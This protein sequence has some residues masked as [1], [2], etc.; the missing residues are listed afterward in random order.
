MLSKIIILALIPIVTSWSGILINYEGNTQI[1]RP[2]GH[3]ET[4][5]KFGLPPYRSVFHRMFMFFFSILPNVSIVSKKDLQ[6]RKIYTGVKPLSTLITNFTLLAEPLGI[7]VFI[8]QTL[9]YSIR[10][11][12]RLL[13]GRR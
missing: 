11:L 3:S 8:T 5:L 10:L 12:I 6:I 4:N 7:R 1:W 13:P 9:R 2:D